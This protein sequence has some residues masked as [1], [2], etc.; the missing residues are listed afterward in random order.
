MFPPS[1]QHAA[2]VSMGRMDMNKELASESAGSSDL[3]QIHHV[4]VV[5]K[6]VRAS[7]EWYRQQFHCDVAYLD[8]SWALLEFENVA[9][10][11]VTPGQHPAHFAVVDPEAG[12][13][14]ELDEH[15]DGTH[16]I[17]I[18]D[19]EGNAVELLVPSVSGSIR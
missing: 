19:P 13:F 14:G 12:R 10:A 17:Y 1:E 18:H 16:S 8:D 4:A 3:D 6:N 7:A 5:V 9:V 15:R 2:K 11:L